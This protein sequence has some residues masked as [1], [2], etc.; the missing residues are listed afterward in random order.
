[1]APTDISAMPPYRFKA[2][3]TSTFNYQRPTLLILWRN[4]LVALA[5]DVDDFNLRILLQVLAQ[6][7]D[8]HIHR[9][10]VE[11]VVVYPN[12]LQGKV[13]L[14]Y[15]VGMRTEQSQQLVLLCSELR[16]LIAN[17]QQLLLCIKGEV[18]DMI[19]C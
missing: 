15:L 1:M 19:E 6:L 10:G 16:L 4:K 7:G 2:V 11:V 18:T 5:M 12:G 17:A 8:V 14:Q 13:T 3:I 9:A